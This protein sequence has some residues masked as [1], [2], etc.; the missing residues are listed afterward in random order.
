MI[1]CKREYKLKKNAHGDLVK[2]KARLETKGNQVHDI[3]YFETLFSVV[4]NSSL[5]ML[6]TLATQNDLKTHHL[7]QWVSGGRSLYITT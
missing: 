6:F 2:Y 5:R 4:R 7:D 3:D 1:P